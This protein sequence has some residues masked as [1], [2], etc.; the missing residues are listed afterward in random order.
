MSFKKRYSGVV[1]PMVTPFNEDGSVDTE[2]VVR[3]ANHIVDGGA[4]GVFVLGTTG[5]SASVS[6][7]EKKKAVEAAAQAVGDRALLYAG[8]SGNCFSECTEAADDFARLGADVFVACAPHY[9]PVPDAWLCRWFREL[10][11]A[12]RR[13]LMIYNIP[14]TTGLSI[15][16]EVIEQLSGH[17]NIAGLKDSENDAQRFEDILSKLGGRDDFVVQ[18]GCMAQALP[19]LRLGADGLVPSSGNVIPEKYTE[20]YEAAQ[21]GEWDRAQAAYDETAE[22]SAKYQKGLSLGESI[23]ELKQMMSRA[24]LCK[25]CVLPPLYR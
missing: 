13:P 1:V 20:L 10:A 15:P 7:A 4:T 2:A 19:G 14:R 21:A 25:P 9:Y 8:I 23:A 24:G 12:V 17:P 18:V 11:D 22:L 6:A 3:V 16:V 5:E